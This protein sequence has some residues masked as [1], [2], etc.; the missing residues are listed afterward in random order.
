MKKYIIYGIIWTLLGGLLLTGCGRDPVASAI[1]AIE[2]GHLQ[3]AEQ[4]LAQA[5]QEDPDNVNA[6][7][8]LYIVQ[9]KMGQ[10]DSALAGFMQVAEMAPNDS[11]PL[12]YAASIQLDNNRWSEATALLTEALRRSPRSPSVQTALAVVDLNTTGAI[13]A[14]DRLLKI[15]A[16]TPAY[17]PAL[18][19][20]GVINRDWLKNQ[21][22]GKKYFQRYLA[23][24]KNDSHT[25]IARVAMTEKIRKPATLPPPAG[26]PQKENPAARDNRSRI[27]Y[28]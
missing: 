6:L 20:L 17:A 2:Q 7:M 16:D 24:E 12:E 22:E 23:L 8:N 28:F 21:S 14:R 26:T 5:L 13:A 11:S 4:I 25:V 19:N 9:L 3:N 10:Q 18:F 15:I 27:K 1:T